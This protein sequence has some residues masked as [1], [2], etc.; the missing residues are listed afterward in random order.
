MKNKNFTYK[1]IKFKNFKRGL[2][3]LCL[4][5]GFLFISLTAEFWANDRPLILYYQGEIYFPVVRNYHPSQ[6]G[7][8]STVI[9]YKK[10][11][12]K[13]EDW[14]VWPIIPWS[15]YESNFKVNKYPSPPSWDNWM[16][17]DNQG[18]DVFT[19]L[20]YGFRYSIGF[21]FLVWIGAFFIG[22]LVGMS[23]GF[24]A[25]WADLIGQRVVEIF[26]SIPV[27]LVL[28]TII[29]VLGV[30]ML[31]LVLYSSIFGW[32][33]ISLYIRNEFLKLRKKDFVQSARSYGASSRK[34]MFTHI[35]PNAL[36]PLITFS[37]FRLA[38][39]IY[40]LAILDYLGFGF[41]PP[42]PSWGE[43]LLQAEEYF[44][45]GWWLAVYPSLFLFFSLI[46]LNFVGEGIR[47]VFDPKTNLVQAREV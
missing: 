24:R 13:K 39:G 46:G 6:L 22:T 12:M 32:M 25:G 19:R 17:T 5:T 3:S 4:L 1:W 30:N 7:L 36:T 43:L 31:T 47:A 21:A 29:S 37:P 27:L 18:R 9:Q 41:P 45:I 8:S 2:Y 35:L 38:H 15:P 16:G 26:Q 28:I 14:S 33:N 10:L 11:E 20:I 23:M 42:T 44:T 34:I 40:F